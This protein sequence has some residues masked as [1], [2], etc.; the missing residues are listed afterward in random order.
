MTTLSALILFGR[1]L[2]DAELCR[3]KAALFVNTVKC[4]CCTCVE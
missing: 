4:A 3:S 2:V 1:G